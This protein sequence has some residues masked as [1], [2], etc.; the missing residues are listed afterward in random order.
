LPSCDKAPGKAKWIT[1]PLVSSV[2]SAE[3]PNDH[4]K[5]RV[6]INSARTL[7]LDIS[8]GFEREETA[9]FRRRILV[10]VRG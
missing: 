5:V 1:Q 8:A 2:V 7:S 10:A 3:T 6:V 4:Q 9:M